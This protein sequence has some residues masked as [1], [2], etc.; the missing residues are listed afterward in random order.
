MKKKR[1]TWAMIACVLLLT[2]VTPVYA[3]DINA[4]EQRIVDYYNG[5]VTYNGKVY[6]FTEEGKQKAYNKLM[7]DDVDLT[8]REVENAIRQAN[9]NLQRG[10]DEGYMQEVTDSQPDTETPGPDTE[11]PDKGNT[12]TPD[13]G[14][15]ET[16]DKNNTE[17][18]GA[19]T[20]NPGGSDDQNGSATGGESGSSGG[21]N[22]GVNGWSGDG[23]SGEANGTIAQRPSYSDAR[24]TDVEGLLKETL[25]EGEYATVQTGSTKGKDGQKSDWAVT[26]E[27]F[28]KG[29]VDVVAKDGSVIL[30]SGLPVKNTGYFSG[31]IVIAAILFVVILG[32]SLAWIASRKK[33]GY[34][35][36]PIITTVA[37]ILVFTLLAGGFLKSETGKWNSVWI[38]GTPEYAYAADMDPN[39]ENGAAGGN[40]DGAWI[41]PLQ[42]EQYGELTCEGISLN[43]PLYYGDS[44]EILGQGAGTYVGGSLPGEG[45]EILIGGHDATFFAPLASIEKGMILS[46]KTSYGSY[47]YEVTGTQVMD[48]MEYQKG[49]SDTEQLVLYTCYPFGA[50][51]RL[52]S[53][54]FFVY[55]KKVSGPE[56]GE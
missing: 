38:L 47:E 46:V 18:G 43:A 37:G 49:R 11:T 7:Q 55:A 12:E 25:E 45:K 54:R 34:F 42:G 23:T 10:I 13:N 5:T 41:P 56:M 2:G 4:A 33:K 24:K 3:G 28:L 22:A 50:E 39:T 26:V 40:V 29:K 21:N 19:T 48:V 35:G 14:N 36:M 30:S 32:A 52:R 15:T 9:A 8:E 6:R 31:G 51:D 27:Q 17:N 53:E 16:P 44:E 1:F 20:T